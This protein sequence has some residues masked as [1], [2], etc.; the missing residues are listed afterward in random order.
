VGGARARQLIAAMTSAFA[1][2]QIAGPLVVSALAARR[3]GFETS[4][5]LAAS[6]LVASAIALTFRSPKK[7]SQ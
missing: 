4:L 1:A 3:S 5:A 6:L 2:G 7:E